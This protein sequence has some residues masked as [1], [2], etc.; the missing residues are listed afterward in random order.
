MNKTKTEL[1]LINRISSLSNYVRIYQI[2]VVHVVPMMFRVNPSPNELEKFEEKLSDCT[3]I[4][5]DKYDKLDHLIQQILKYPF[6][7]EIY[8]FHQAKWYFKDVV[9]KLEMELNNE[10]WH[11]NQAFA[12][13]ARTFI[14][15]SLILAKRTL[16]LFEYGI[17][18]YRDFPN[19]VKYL[20]ERDSVEQRPFNKIK[21]NWSSYQ[22]VVTMQLA[23][24]AGVFKGFYSEKPFDKNFAKAL[25]YTFEFYYNGNKQS[26]KSIYSQFSQALSIRNENRTKGYQRRFYYQISPFFSDYRKKLKEKTLDVNLTKQPK[27]GVNEK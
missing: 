23:R 2:G 8:L 13:L 14:K 12:I 10:I 7:K 11:G 15:E 17:G 21:V 24:M 4:A 16:N 27:S 5:L 20:K 19:G 9:F 26:S 3:S 22:M 6:E 18:V 1:E 25:D